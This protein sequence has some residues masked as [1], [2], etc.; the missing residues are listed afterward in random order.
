MSKQLNWRVFQDDLEWSKLK[1]A[2]IKEN[3][4]Y[5]EF[6]EQ[7]KEYELQSERGVWPGFEF[8]NFGLVGLRY[9][10]GHPQYRAI[11]DLCDPLKD[12]SAFPEELI[13][14]VLPRLF[15]QNAVK[16]LVVKS[17]PVKVE[18][19]GYSSQPIEN[20]SRKGLNPYERIYKI[21]LRKKKSQIF[22]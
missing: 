13:E 6:F 14:S 3:F 1:L 2:L 16:Q 22:L 11:R 17:H 10:V 7:F 5:R 4:A 8:S 21:D 15:Y 12:I 19:E 20:I 9:F 18:F